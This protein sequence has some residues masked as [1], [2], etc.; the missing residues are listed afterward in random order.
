[1]ITAPL[2]ETLDQ[3]EVQFVVDFMPPFSRIIIRATCEYGKAATAIPE[4]IIFIDMIR[5]AAIGGHR[6]LCE[7][8]REWGMARTFYAISETG[9]DIM[10]ESAACGE[11]FARAR[12]LCIL[13]K[14]WG[15]TNFRGMLIHATTRGNRDL[16]VLA[17]RWSGMSNSVLDLNTM[18]VCAV[19]EG[20]QGLCALAKEW[21]EES[22]SD[23][24]N[25][26]LSAAA[27]SGNYG[28]CVLAKDWMDTAGIEVNFGWMI[29]S[30]D[31]CKDGCA[32]WVIKRLA[33][34]WMEEAN[35]KS[36]EP[37][38]IFDA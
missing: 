26:M 4:K 10:L 15:A 11:D 27:E 5:N 1:M 8:A 12:D 33:H 35:D 6:D 2:F 32:G 34:Q 21:I 29:N 3:Y 17:H 14:E 22:N 7:L 28:L 24:L 25:I 16:C 37:R 19:R 36:A 18:L 23:P 13:A 9:C 31:C 30:A 20:D 38:G